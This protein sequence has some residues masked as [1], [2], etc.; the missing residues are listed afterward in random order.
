MK[1][2]SLSAAAAAVAAG[3]ALAEVPRVATDIAPV[4]GLAARVMQ[5]L[6]A[7]D[8]ILPPG[9][10]PHGYA[11]R[12]SEARAL[13]QADAVFWIGAGLT[14]WLGA[15]IGQLAPDARVT[16]LLEVPGTVRLMFREGVA[17]EAHPHGDADENHREQPGEDGHGH[18]NDHS[19]AHGDHGDDSIDPH[20]WLAPENGKRWLDVIAAELSALDPDNAGAYAA[21]AAAGKTEIDA[22]AAKAAA[23]LEPL[24]SKGFIVFHD[25]YQYFEQSFGLAAAGAISL[26]DASEPGPARIA[27][28]R[29]KVADLGIACV[30]SEPQFNPGLVAT[31]LD[32]TAAK[33]VVIDPVGTAIAPGPGFYPAL[34]QELGQAMAACQ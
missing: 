22:A 17:F 33:T 12:P 26:G 23:A 3:A 14:P 16:G 9:A 28:I 13:E 11:M 21:N 18:G 34:L 19:E 2:F 4:H 32:G 6:G 15:A 27:E 1:I 25:A 5:G 7:P 10:S 8:L 30:F 29:D 24:Q 31:V 20:A